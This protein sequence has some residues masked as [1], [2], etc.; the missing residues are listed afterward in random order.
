MK[1]KENYYLYFYRKGE[2]I[3]YI[4]RTK[5]F[6]LRHKEHCVHKDRC[7]LSNYDNVLL[8]EY[9]SVF[10]SAAL[11]LYLIAKY[12]PFCNK[13]EKYFYERDPFLEFAFNAYQ[14][15]TEI[16]KREDLLQLKE[17][18]LLE[19]PERKKGG[20]PP[21]SSS[22][23]NYAISLAMNKKYSIKEVT[24]MSGVSSSVI[25]RELKKRK[26]VRPKI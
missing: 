2:D 14:T 1:K 18:D 15:K 10:M 17:E 3:L 9:S 8:I 21:T 22:K 6:H 11:E 5:N 26:L 24:E 13:A 23:L 25:Y 12:N 20:R 19:L 4:G 16:L 7:V